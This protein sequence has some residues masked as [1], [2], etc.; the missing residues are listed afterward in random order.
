MLL[1]RASGTTTDCVVRS[2]H[3]III[4]CFCAVLLCGWCAHYVHNGACVQWG[5][6]ANHYTD[7]HTHTHASAHEPHQ[8]YAHTPLPMR[9]LVGIIEHRTSDI[10]QIADED[11]ATET[12][13]VIVTRRAHSPPTRSHIPYTLRASSI[14]TR[15]IMSGTHACAQSIASPS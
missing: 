2:R 11:N 1:C 15:N 5:G 8:G 9:R 14:P 10:S 13:M 6:G 12:E 7:T 4:D 3:I